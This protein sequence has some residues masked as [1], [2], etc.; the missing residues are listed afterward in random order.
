LFPY[1]GLPVALRALRGR[2]FPL[3][4]LVNGGCRL[5]QQAPLLRDRELTVRARLMSVTSDE[6][7]T[8]LCQRIV[9]EQAGTPDALT[10]DV[11]AVVRSR[12]PSGPAK[13][14]PLE[15]L[16][17][18]ARELEAW[19]LPRDAGLRFA[20]LTGDVNPL[21]WLPPYA[22]LLGY[23]GAILHGFAALA[24]AHAGL[25]RAFGRGRVSLLDVRFV[26]PI[27]LPARLSLYVDGSRLFVAAKGQDPCMTGSFT[28]A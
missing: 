12:R 1:W 21:H 24:R 28:L 25:G 27:P 18:A 6:R 3:L 23:E 26:R 11:Y 19:Q 13:R 7:R 9:T 17:E 2:R 4:K 5:Q 20:L 14:K 8:V 10:A 22:R 16:P 15:P